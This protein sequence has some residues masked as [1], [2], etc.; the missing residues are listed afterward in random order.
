M[1]KNIVVTGGSQG[2][3]RA[4]AEAF[5]AEGDRVV[6]TSRRPE[7]AQK[8]LSEANSDKLF[9]L[10]CDC[11][12]QADVA[13]LYDYTKKTIGG[14][15]VLVNNAAIF[16]GGTVHKTTIADFDK[17]MSINVR[18]VFLVTKAFLPDMLEQKNGNIIN[19]ASSA[20]RNGAYNMTVYAMAKAA[21]TSMTKSMAIDYGRDG[22][23]VNAICPS[24]T[25]TEMFVSGNS[26]EVFD[27]FDASNPMGRI[28][29]PEEVAD[30]AIFLAS[31][32]SSYITGQ[33]LSVDGGL[34]SWNGEPKQSDGR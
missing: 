19:I 5:L 12:E 11:S 20:A 18:G 34:T 4:I 30:A 10:N 31:E 13:A 32:K 9:Y 24:A 33:L 27:M 22:V 17:Q 14:C 8:F 29:N 21:I 28:G 1:N 16:I 26:Q 2:I 6:I 7:P 23:R 3:G 15:D 25:R